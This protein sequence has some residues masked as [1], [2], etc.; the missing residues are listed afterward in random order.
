MLREGRVLRVDSV[1]GLLGVRALFRNPSV[2]LFWRNFPVHSD[3]YCAA[4][5]SRRCEFAHLC[6]GGVRPLYEVRAW[7]HF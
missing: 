2:S 1:E 5:Y 3:A 6:S 7:L 4:A